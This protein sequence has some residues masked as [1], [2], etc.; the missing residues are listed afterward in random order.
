MKD[1]TAAK[2]GAENEELLSDLE[3]HADDFQSNPA[4]TTYHSAYSAMANSVPVIDFPPEDG[5][6]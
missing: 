6:E 4:A 1:E 5:G 3:R 2:A